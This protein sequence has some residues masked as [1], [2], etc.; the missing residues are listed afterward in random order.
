MRPATQE[1]HGKC[2]CGRREGRSP[3]IERGRAA[4][5][6]RQL[7]GL[8]CCG[9][10]G[11]NPRTCTVRR[12]PGST[13]P[14]PAAWAMECNAR[15]WTGQREGS[16]VCFAQRMSLNIDMHRAE[17]MRGGAEQAPSEK[18][19]WSRDYC[20]G[21]RSR[22]RRR[23][24]HGRGHEHGGR[25]CVGQNGWAKQ[26]PASERVGEV[27]TS[28]RCRLRRL[29]C[30]LRDRSAHGAPG[31]GRANRAGRRRA[32][33]PPGA[34]RPGRGGCARGSS[35]GRGGVRVECG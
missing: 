7:L 28:G 33:Q 25:V 2:V 20:G 31:C 34:R 21:K 26:A 12:S 3:R 19:E 17:L 10:G 18:A 29:G 24:E 27:R 5:A 32:K 8:R 35:V 15:N 4:P 22:E 13:V 11:S 23:H 14:R 1:T 9:T 6:G 30:P 16:I